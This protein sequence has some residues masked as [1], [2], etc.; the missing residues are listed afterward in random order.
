MAIVLRVLLFI[1]API[2]A[3][4]VSRD[5]LNFGVIEAL[6]AVI[7]IA[8]FCLVVAFWR[9]GRLVDSA[10]RDSHVT[11]RGSTQRGRRIGLDRSSK[12]LVGLFDQIFIRHLAEPAQ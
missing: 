2:T 8:A 4:F 7:L 3:L 1:A 5:A 6:I 9:C 10:A 12:L 11:L